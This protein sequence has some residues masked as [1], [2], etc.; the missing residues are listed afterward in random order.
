MQFQMSIILTVQASIITILVAICFHSEREKRKQKKVIQNLHLYNETLLDM[1]DGVR[2]VKHEIF[3]FVQSL[4]G[5]I[6]CNDIVGVR[7]MTNSFYEECKEISNMERLN[8][9][10]INHPAVYNLMINKYY[11][12]CQDNVKMNVEVNCNIQKI[13]L[14]SFCLCRI[15]GILLDNAIEAAGECKDKIVNVRFY[16][17]PKE[18]I[19]IIENSYENTQMDFAKIFEKGYSTKVKSEEHGLGLWKLKKMLE[20]RDNVQLQTKKEELFQQKVLIQRK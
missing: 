8:P 20:K 6:K 17:S 7:N 19:I 2:G 9:E 13:S 12:A 16:Q 11:K 1:Y 18:D 3:N 14:D 4:N 10:I 5:Y 15:L